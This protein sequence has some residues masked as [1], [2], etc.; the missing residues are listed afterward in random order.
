MNL[1]GDETAKVA[2]DTPSELA[3][4]GDILR[5]HRPIFYSKDAKALRTGWNLA[6]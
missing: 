4:L 2:V 6:E 5:N 3:A 1:D